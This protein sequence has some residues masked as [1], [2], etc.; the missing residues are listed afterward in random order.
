M[1]K[2]T[3][4]TIGF[5]K[6]PF[7]D[8]LESSSI[9]NGTDFIHLP[10]YWTGDVFGVSN[11]ITVMRSILDSGIIDLN[12]VILFT[13]AYDTLV[14]S[15]SAEI[16]LNFYKLNCDLLISGESHFWPPEGRE[17]EKSYFED[18]ANLWRYPNSGCYIGFGWAIKDMVDFCSEKLDSGD[19]GYSKPDDQALVQ[20]YIIHKKSDK[21]MVISIDSNAEFFATLNTT[22]N[23]F[24]FNRRSVFNNKTGLPVSVV[25]ANSNKNNI[26]I[27]YKIWSLLGE[28]NP[29]LQ[30]WDIQVAKCSD[31][32]ISYDIENKKLKYSEI[33]DG[34]C[35]FFFV[36]G[37]RRAIGIVP[38]FGVI[39]PREDGHVNCD[40]QSINSWEI[41]NYKDEY[42]TFHQ[43]KLNSYI[44]LEENEILNDIISTRIPLNYFLHI[45]CQ[46]LIKIA[47]KYEANF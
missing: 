26:Q 39:T 46:D 27:L 7:I 13:D 44:L 14:V 42:L 30:D 33:L 3:H 2:L 34:N 29:N 40:S 6:K 9:S 11:K 32:F 20:N 10:K 19:W 22:V 28:A 1:S 8:I 4:V 37:R 18:T 21:N 43:K 5:P 16:L 41:L 12:S 31:K 45:S 36:K 23:Y 17:L 47:A 24:S 25:H 15:H 38:T 35:L